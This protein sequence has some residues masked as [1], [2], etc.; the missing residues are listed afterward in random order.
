ML[1]NEIR[2]LIRNLVEATEECQNKTC[3]KEGLSACTYKAE[4]LSWNIHEG[5]LAK[6]TNQQNNGSVLS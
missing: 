5:S 6:Q 1:T 3:T 2:R 4:A